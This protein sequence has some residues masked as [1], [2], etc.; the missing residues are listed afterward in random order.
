[1][2]E[3]REDVARKEKRFNHSFGDPLLGTVLYL[4]IREQVYVDIG[5]VKRKS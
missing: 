1:M 2:G 4:C 5:V 3:S